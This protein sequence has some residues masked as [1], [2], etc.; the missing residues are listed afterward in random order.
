MQTPLLGQGLLIIEVSWSHSDT[1]HSVG[2]FCTSDQPDA[3]TSTWRQNTLK[4]DTHVPGGI[5]TY[6]H[7]KRAAS[8]PYL[9]EREPTEIGEEDIIVWINIY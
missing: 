6:N 8:D 1:Q 4:T 3:E 7:S 5:R 9:R 2:L